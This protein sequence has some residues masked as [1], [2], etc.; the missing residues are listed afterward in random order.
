MAAIIKDVDRLV[1][2]LCTIWVGRLRLQANIARFQRSPTTKA[3]NQ[4]KSK[5][6]KTTLPGVFQ[7]AP[8]T[9][10]HSNTY[11]HV[12]K[13]GHQTQSV[14]N[15]SNPA[16]VLDDSC[17]FQSDLSL[18]VV[19]KLKEF[20]SLANI[21]TLLATEGFDDIV[22]QYMGGFWVLLKFISK[23]KKDK[24]MGYVG[25][26]SWFAKLQHTSTDFEI[27]ERDDALYFHRKRLCIKTALDDTIFETFKIIVKGKIFWI[28]AKEVTGWTPNFNIGEDDLSDSDDESLHAKNDDI[29]NKVT[30]DDSKI[31]E[32]PETIFEQGKQGESKS[33]TVKEQLNDGLEDAQSEDPFNLYKLLNKKP[34]TTNDVLQSIEEPKYPSEFTPRETSEAKSNMESHTFRE[35]NENI[36]NYQ[37]K[38]KEQTILKKVPSMKS[39][40]NGDVSVCSG[41]VIV[42]GDF[43]EVH[44]QD[45]RFGS[46]FNVHGAAAF[47][48]FILLGGLM[49]VPT[50]G[51]S[52]T[53]SHKSAS[54]MSKLDCFLIFEY[55]FSSCPNISAIILD[56]YLSDHRPILLRESN[57]DYGPTP[58]R[59]YHYWFE[60]DEGIR[61][62][63]KDKNDKSKNL[64]KDLEKKLA[65]IDLFLDKGD[66]SSDSLKEQGDENSKYFHG[67]IN[68][69]SN[70]LAIRGILIDGAWIEDPKIVKDEFFTHIKD[71]F[72]NTCSNRLTLDMKFPNKLSIDQKTDLERPFTKEEIKGVVLQCCKAK[73]KQTMLFKVDFENAFDSVRWDFL[74]DVLKK[75]CFG[76]R[77]YDWIQS[78]LR[79]S[80]GSILVNGS[81]TTEFQFHKGGDPLSSFLFILIMES[82]HLSFQ[83]VVNACMFKG[84]T[85]VNSLQLSYLFYVDDMVFLVQRCDSNLKTIIRVLDC[86][87]RALGVRINL[88]KSKIMGIAVK[89]SKVDLAAADIGC[90]TLKSPFTYIGVKV[91]GRVDFKDQKISLVKWDNVLASKEKGGLGVLSF[92][93]LNRALIFK[94]IWRFRTQNLSLWARVIKAIHGVDGKIGYNVPLKSLFPR[95]YA[96]ESVKS[97]TVAAKASQL[98]LASSPRRMWF[99]RYQVLESFQLLRFVIYT[100]EDSA[101]KTRWIKVV[102]KKI[103]FMLGESKWT[104]FP[105]ALTFPVEV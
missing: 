82:L 60:I 96:L 9:H 34:S 39:N 3:S 101:P 52:F 99:G 64:K 38:I 44:S 8:G 4:S 30:S 18:L 53:W 93:A 103:N 102:P 10:Q 83:N 86:F 7:K 36:R 61:T 26:G 49:K 57:L 15:A 91:G 42:M 11:V 21:K 72:I 68:K 73:K 29:L 81:P 74:D 92:Y 28:R 104:T 48:N 89:N 14:E 56:R 78:C 16:L 25:V 65:D 33:S 51:Y 105:R 13:T 23:P 46:I 1:N 94:W 35:G 50:R 45:E 66:A 98:G 47:N 88:Y 79:S 41:E 58:F 22:I 55:F 40:E 70:N 87:F 59:F 24:F 63:I 12:V 84:V 32:I 76:G 100:L 20:D 71:R 62:W 31:E 19:G 95:I 37:E 85:L 27:D 5:V 90:M 17:I 67:I 97:I 80:R 69:Q 6:V 77:W 2:N 75:F 43:N 54:K